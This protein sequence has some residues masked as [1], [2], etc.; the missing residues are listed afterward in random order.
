MLIG[1]GVVWLK[2]QTPG[3]WFYRCGK[4]VIVFGCQQ[5]NAHQTMFIKHS[6]DKVAILIVYV[7]DEVVTGND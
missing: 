6:N 5:S 3:A 4:A 1:K 2:R 7:D